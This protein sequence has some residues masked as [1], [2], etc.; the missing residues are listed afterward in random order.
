MNNKNDKFL[1]KL[2]D[3]LVRGDILKIVQDEKEAHLAIRVERLNK[4]L[5]K[6]KRV[7]DM[8]LEN[9]KLDVLRK[10][11]YNRYIIKH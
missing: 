11:Y 9:D 5:D 1:G 4:Y 7:Q 3:M 6:L 8:M 2:Y 10:M